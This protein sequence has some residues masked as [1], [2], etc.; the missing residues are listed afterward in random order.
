[1]PSHELK[2]ELKVHKELEM[3]LFML[4]NT[5]LVKDGKSQS[6]ASAPS[7][8][9]NYV[10]FHG[11]GQIRHNGQVDLLGFASGTAGFAWEAKIMVIVNGE[12]K[13]FLN[14]PIRC[15]TDRN[16]RADLKDVSLT[17]PAV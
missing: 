10:E 14:S 17:W 2:F 6:F 7:N 12:A 13:E 15:R 16:G 9:G 4:E 8:D 1:M 5:V 3:D 11:T